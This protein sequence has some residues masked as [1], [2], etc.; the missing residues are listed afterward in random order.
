MTRFNYFAEQDAFTRDQNGMSKMISA[1]DALSELIFTL[2]GN[3]DYSV[4]AQLVAEKGTTGDTLPAILKRLTKAE[5]PV[6]ITF[7]QGKY[8]LTL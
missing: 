5:V 3:G 7:R 4:V 1:I 2:K 6:D 8:V